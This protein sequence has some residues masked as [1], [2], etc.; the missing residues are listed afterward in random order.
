MRNRR[1][2]TRSPIVVPSPSPLSVPVSRYS[3]S[4]VSRIRVSSARASG[5]RRF[6]R[7]ASIR[8]CRSGVNVDSRDL[9]TESVAIASFS[10]LWNRLCRDG[11]DYDQLWIAL[12]EEAATLA[13]PKGPPSDH[14]IEVWVPGTWFPPTTDDSV[15]ATAR[16]PR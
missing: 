16:L 1:N 9:R 4:R 11:A 5:L 2:A 14:S 10:V 12:I 13:P 15:S 8:A 6:V 7:M 3:R